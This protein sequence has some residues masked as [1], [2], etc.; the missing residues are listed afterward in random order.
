M[1]SI[2]TDS[3]GILK[4]GC[5]FSLGIRDENYL[6][7]NL[8]ISL[9]P[10]DAY[11]PYHT[12]QSTSISTP[13]GLPGIPVPSNTAGITYTDANGQAWIADDIDEKMK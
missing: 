10:V 13:N 2:K 11:E 4:I 9:N 6:N 7:D 8:I 5:A 12:P 1:H 3:T